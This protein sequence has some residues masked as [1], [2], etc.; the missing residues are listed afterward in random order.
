[1]TPPKAALDS[2]PGRLR[3]QSRQGPANERIGSRARLLDCQT[4]RLGEKPSQHQHQQ[5]QEN[6]GISKEVSSPPEGV[7][8]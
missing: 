5:E 8:W 2:R 6:S 3:R 7:L 4:R 1:M